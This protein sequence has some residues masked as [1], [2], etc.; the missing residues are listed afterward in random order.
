MEF[1][2]TF[3]ILFVA[4]YSYLIFAAGRRKWRSFAPI[5]DDGGAGGA[6]ALHR[7]TKV[8]NAEDRQL[9]P[10]EEKDQYL[11]RREAEAAA[12]NKKNDQIHYAYREILHDTLNAQHHLDFD[13]LYDYQSLPVLTVPAHL[14]RALPRPALNNYRQRK[15]NDFISRCWPGYAARRAM[16][17][18]KQSNLYHHDLIA[19]EEQ[20]KG[21]ADAIVQLRIE[22]EERL[23]AAIS[24]NDLIRQKRER[25]AVNYAAGDEF[26]V[27]AYAKKILELSPYPSWLSRQVNT[28]YVA[29]S[30]QLIVEYALPKVAVIPKTV[31][32][33]YIKSKDE[34]IGR[35]RKQRD[36]DADY[37]SLISAL[38][39]KSL[40]EVFESDTENHI[41]VCCFNGYLDTVDRATGMKVRPCLVSTRVT[42][43]VFERIDLAHVDPALCVRN[44]GAHVSRSASELQA[45]KPIIEFNMNDRRFVDQGDVSFLS[46]AQNL[47]GL[48][49]YEFER[50]IVKLFQDLGLDSKLTQASR[51]GGV[52]CVAYDVRPI[53]GG[54]VVIQAKRY[55]HT[56]G[57]SAVR[58][59]YG[60]MMNE[61][62]NKGILVTTSGYG[63]DAFNFAK[64]KPIE[65]VDGGGLLHYLQSV[66]IEA[67]IVMPQE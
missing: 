25:L 52:D 34:I 65:L 60:T 62:A 51:D 40:Y 23:S 33:R 54:K 2:Y 20:E 39:L 38:A 67:R 27:A 58:D 32:Y 41:E 16:A 43:Q 36:I 5:G 12:K 63:P 19:W 55:R 26:I 66:G 11:R 42:K 14:T 64:G 7:L 56:V 3:L 29:A 9:T 45:V 44:L 61:G 59:L 10:R 53:I 31:D 4:Y 48:N 17:E 1:L 30:K 47:M 21:R 37:T 15:V 6:V 50:L 18:E 49:P 24:H 57:V 13:S 22:F 8:E 46:S 35:G 28:L